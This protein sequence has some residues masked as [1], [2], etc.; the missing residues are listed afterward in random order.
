M[1]AIEFGKLVA[2][3]RQLAGRVACGQRDVL[4]DDAER[5]RDFICGAI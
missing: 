4:F 2:V 3:E 1:N 5:D